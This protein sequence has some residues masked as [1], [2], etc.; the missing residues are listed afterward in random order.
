MCKQHRELSE[1]QQNNPDAHKPSYTKKPHGPDKSSC[2]KQISTLVSKQ[3]VA[4]IQK[5]NKSMSTQHLLH[6]RLYQMMSNILCQWYS[7]L[8]PN[9]SQLQISL[10]PTRNHPTG[11]PSSSRPITKCLDGV[12][13]FPPSIHLRGEWS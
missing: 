3:V 13:Q 9:I 10:H 2:S 7:P 1:W 8:L 4:K 5:L 6:R 12:Q 11:K